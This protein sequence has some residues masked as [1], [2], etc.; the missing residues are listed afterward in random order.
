MQRKGSAVWQG[1]LRDGKGT[2][3]TDSGVLKQTQYSFSTRFENGI[4]TN[5]EEL[6]AAAHAGCFSMALSAQL[7]QAGLTPAKLETTATVTL[8]K[9][10]DAFAITKSHLDSGGP[11]AGG[12]QGE[13]RRRGEGGRN[14]LSG[15]QALQGGDQRQRAPRG[16]RRRW[17]NPWR[18]P[19]PPGPPS[20]HI[21]AQ[22]RAGSAA[23]CATLPP[24]SSFMTA[25]EY[26]RRI[27]CRPFH[28]LQLVRLAAPGAAPGRPRAAA[29]HRRVQRSLNPP[30]SF[31][32]IIGSDVRMHVP[33]CTGS[34]NATGAGPYGEVQDDERPECVEACR[35]RRTGGGS[36]GGARRMGRSVR[37]SVRA[38]GTAAGRH[39]E[40]AGTGFAGGPGYNR[41]GHHAERHGA[42]RHVE[43]EDGG[44]GRAR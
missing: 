29:L 35:A 24:L 40:G 27:E 43:H 16:L 22:R 5:P 41:T 1:G 32:S 17:A 28:D 31:R 37:L 33:A 11:R 39:L 7:G 10:G 23:V 21:S 36:V 13:V 9:V 20:F 18:P 26:L 34:C 30:S 3:S 6:L 14:G 12:R 8:E 25:C 2:M 19:R 15:L 38:V 42:E 44:S 4:G